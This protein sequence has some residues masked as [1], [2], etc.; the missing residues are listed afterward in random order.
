MKL[1]LVFEYGGLAGNEAE[2]PGTLE[3]EFDATFDRTPTIGEAISI[4][5]LVLA[6]SWVLWRV[7]GV[8]EIHVVTQPGYEAWN[9]RRTEL[10]AAGWTEV[11]P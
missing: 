11:E 1:K 3:K 8:T 5:H 6:V 10:A 2:H 4:D 9:A 7:D